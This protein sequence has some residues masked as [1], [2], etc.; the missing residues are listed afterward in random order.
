[1]RKIAIASR[2]RKRSVPH[3]LQLLYSN[4]S[5]ATPTRLATTWVPFLFP[6]RFA[7]V[8]KSPPRLNPFASFPR[9]YE[10]K[11]LILIESISNR[12]PGKTDF[13]L[14]LS[15]FFQH[16]FVDRYTTNSIFPRSPSTGA[17]AAATTTHAPISQINLFARCCLGNGY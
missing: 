16:C 4:S 10:R 3:P 13:F 9:R 12:V 1:M 7:P 5:P 11:H 2:E 14:S 6:V 8:A 17:T 15:F